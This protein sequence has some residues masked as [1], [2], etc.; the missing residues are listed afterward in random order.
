MEELLKMYGHAGPPSDIL[1]DS[2]EI[3]SLAET[4]EDEDDESGRMFCM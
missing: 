2:A 4:E 1:S 3:S